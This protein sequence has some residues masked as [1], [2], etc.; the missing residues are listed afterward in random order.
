ML[1]ISLLI[2]SNSLAF[3]SMDLS[4]VNYSKPSEKI[5]KKI[6]DEDIEGLGLNDIY[7]FKNVNQHDKQVEYY[8]NSADGTYFYD[9]DGVIS[10]V[11]PLESDL[12]IE[13]STFW[14]FRE[15]FV[16]S[17][18]IKLKAQKSFNTKFNFM[19]GNDKNN[20]QT[21]VKAYESI[22]FGEIYKDI[23][24]ETNINESS[25]EKIF[26]VGSK[27][28]V[29][30]I[31]IDVDGVSEL[32]VNQ[33]HELVFNTEQGTVRLSEPYAYQLI[34]NEII[35]IPVNYTIQGTQYGFEVG[36]YNSEYDL[37]I[38]PTYIC[39]Y[40]GAG[41]DYTRT[42]EIAEDSD[43][44]IYL[45]GNTYSAS[46]PTTTGVISEVRNGNYDMFIA[47]LDSEFTTLLAATY[48]GGSGVGG[49]KAT[50]IEISE[51]GRIYISG[52]TETLD[53][54]TT[55]SVEPYDDTLTSEGAVVFE[56]DSD[57]ENILRMTF[58]DDSNGSTRLAIDTDGSIII[59]G[60][61]GYSATS[62]SNSVPTTAGTYREVLTLNQP[63][64][65]V[66]RF[67]S[68]LTT[69]QASTL[70][71]GSGTETFSNMK[72]S[73]NGDIIILG[74]N[75]YGNL[76]TTANAY[77]ATSAGSYDGFVSVLSSDLTTLK[78][79][80]MFGTNQLDYIYGLAEDYYGNIYVSGHTSGTNLE[81]TTGA[82]QEN[83][84]ASKDAF[85]LKF[86]RFLTNLEA[87]TY[88]GGSKT[89]YAV[90]IEVTDSNKL[91]VVGGTG[92]SE[93][94]VTS[95]AFDSTYN[96]G[97]A[98]V[99]MFDLSLENLTYSTFVGGL[100]GGYG[101][102]VLISKT[103]DI[104]VTGTI[105]SDR[106]PV[107]SGVYQTKN[108]ASY[109][110]FFLKIPENRT[111]LGAA[112]FV[113]NTSPD[114]FN[115]IGYGGYTQSKSLLQVDGALSLNFGISYNSIL[116]DG[117]NVG[118]GW[119]TNVSK[120][121][122][123]IN[124]DMMVLE[125]ENG[126][127]EVLHNQ[128]PNY[129][130]GNDNT[131]FTSAEVDATT[132]N[133]TTTGD[134]YVFDKYDDQGN[135]IETTLKTG[136]ELSYHYD[137]NNRL[138]KITEIRSQRY[139][140]LLY[141][142]GTDLIETVRDNSGRIV[143]L[144]YTGNELLNTITYA[145]GVVSTFAYN[146]KN[147]LTS[148]TISD[149]NDSYKLFENSYDEL[150]RLETVD[151]NH[152]NNQVIRYEY[153]EESLA[154]HV[155][156]TTTNQD[157]DTS[158]K[159]YDSNFNVLE[160]Y[161]ELNHEILYTYLDGVIKSVS[162]SLGNTTSYTFNDDGQ[163]TTVK[164][165]LNEVTIYTYDAEKNLETISN[166]YNGTTTYGYDSNNR[167][168]TISKDITIVDPDDYS[169]TNPKSAVTEIYYTGADIDYVI[170][171][172]GYAKDYTTDIYGQLEKVESKYY[173]NSTLS[174]ASESV[175]YDYDNV[176]RLTSVIDS[177]SHEYQMEYF[178]NDQIKKITNP[179]LQTYSYEYF[180]HGGINTENNYENE[181]TSYIY[182]YNLNLKEIHD[183]IIESPSDKI[184]S[185]LYDNQNR[186]RT[187]TDRNGNS[188]V[189]DYYD[190]ALLEKVTDEEGVYSRYEYYNNGTLKA[191]YQLDPDI[192]STEKKVIEYSYNALNNPLTIKDALNN[193][194]TNVYDNIGRLKNTKDAENNYT[195]FEY[196][197]FNRIV[198]STNDNLDKARNVFSLAGK[199]KYVQDSNDDFTS[200]ASYL[201]AYSYDQYGRV[202]EIKYSGT[203]RK[204]I[205]YLANSNLIE[206]SA[207]GRSESTTYTYDEL[208]RV[209]TITDYL[210]V[211][212][213]TYDDVNNKV[214][215]TTKELGTLTTIASL[216]YEYDA[217]GRVVKYTDENSNV[218]EYSY[219]PNG[220]LYQLTYPGNKVVEYTYN[221]SSQLETVKDWNNNVTTYAYNSNSELSSMTRAN[222][223][224]ESYTYFK[225]GWL[226]SKIDKDSS[227]NVISEFNYTYDNVGNILTENG[228]DE[229]ITNV[230]DNL[231]ELNQ[232][233]KKDDSQTLLN[234]YSYTY[235]SEGN[236]LTRSDENGVVDTMTYIDGNILSTYNSSSVVYD[237]DGNMTTGPL[238]GT[239]E[240]YNY[241][242]RN[243][244]TS[245]GDHEYTY[246]A[247]GN[248][249]STKVGT[250][251]T[252][253]VVNPLAG[254]NQIL[255]KTSPL[256]VDTYYVYGLGLISEE[257]S[258]NQKYYHFDN[259]GSTIAITDSAETTTDTFEYGPYGELIN[260]T[261]TSDVSFNY[262]GRFGVYTDEN[263]LVFMLTRY[264]NP[265][266]SRF[267]N[268]DIIYGNI[269]NGHTLNQFLF[270]FSNPSRYT[271]PTGRFPF[272]IPL[273][274][275]GLEILVGAAVAAVG[276][277][278]IVEEIKVS[279]SSRQTRRTPTIHDSPTDE[280]S[281]Y[282]VNPGLSDNI[283]EF[284]DNTLPG[285]SILDESQS[286][287]LRPGFDYHEKSVK[288]NI[289]YVEGTS[290]AVNKVDDLAS[291]IKKWI[292]NDGRVITNK[293]GDK[294]FLSS[295]GTK[296]VRYDINNPSPHNSPHGHVE[297]LINGK[298]QKSGPLYPTDVPQN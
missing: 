20:Y 223:T 236:I 143:S 89:E 2:A 190:N 75:Y 253:F 81:T 80:T 234:H 278:V 204:L 296:R 172:D 268:Q 74:S 29:L 141:K 288:D 176:G 21:K 229:N 183:P 100:M 139:I 135:L 126:T 191:I 171:P 131:Q 140:E 160:E 86:N 82:Y 23:I 227:N 78:A 49:E 156:V 122:S 188:T 33:D 222:G 64:V 53:F 17:N 271:D 68:E 209:E 115:A 134:Q 262:N 189:Y 138:D 59:A 42:S 52:Y 97:E 287:G 11:L 247:S 150:G 57:L 123:S 36:E 147:Q 280:L 241:N 231:Y 216:E 282:G 263:D 210:N 192:A 1:V 233:V 60:E 27:G 186:L 83:F 215:L 258:S 242:T 198:E 289:F 294:V 161:D 245:V 99:R 284:V 12:E 127:S 166:A 203:T 38:D 4:N 211:R 265:E 226:E 148:E 19:I 276:S 15:T 162:D 261:G 207:N 16:D 107:T 44:N 96:Y 5:E 199:L 170:G 232:Q 259:R 14:A 145:N 109:V 30:D 41:K 37:I 3:A 174:P 26:T 43:G 79:S 114:I 8:L 106:M 91:I 260:R 110:S 286:T 292:G 269:S 244:L 214:T 111:G 6:R 297:E 158:Y 154:E 39:S 200:D 243:Q 87:G 157:G 129:N 273:I 50:S 67:D 73:K 32:T 267:V 84:D 90:A 28:N 195:H 279:F 220:E 201:H 22:S 230:Y 98:Y 225:N 54:P 246:D 93:F 71:G 266:I 149:S 238:N 62:P 101:T 237:D 239:M 130:G 45:V 251:I 206:T 35:D 281:Y 224:V 7:F 168:T 151:D 290:E 116:L 69:L 142:T 184:V 177:L 212:E 125:T 70:F 274:V 208:N 47:K 293:N 119:R 105:S 275:K 270:A 218:I 136:E 295:D 235:D 298:W 104:L 132:N 153:D 46:F 217:N 285:T 40:F 48:L 31:Q 55:T 187:T 124:D 163:I 165:P 228:N 164:N 194:T 118:Q 117:E 180:A 65:Y 34:D 169:A 252:E 185:N 56:V 255:I 254:Y 113:K 248:R 58:F 283:P 66:A 182:D 121:I 94:E 112:G 18:K 146:T 10:S 221:G 92:S 196:D 219:Y 85:I 264:Y 179:L 173:E 213:Y 13:E 181:T 249:L 240:T 103:D 205:S 291:N 159:I 120:K 137:V 51:S 88:I 63:D 277:Y 61:A 250:D 167:I 108:Y 95:D 202:D 197:E 193:V 72:L 257:T 152:V 76:P 77:S 128:N 133:V 144:T 24:L 102:D 178:D 155:I 25:I 9:A 272:A 256:S 175:S